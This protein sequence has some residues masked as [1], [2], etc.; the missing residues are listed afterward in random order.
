MSAP[1]PP[2]G[3]YPDGSTPNVVR[4]FDG[5]R[6][7]EHVT[8]VAPAAAPAVGYAAPPGGYASPAGGYGSPVGGYAS[9]PGGYVPGSFATAA[10][11]PTA[12]STDLGPGNGL[13]WV[14]PVGRS[15]QSIVAG[16]V[17]LFALF[18]WFMGMAGT[19][20]VAFGAVVGLLSVALGILAI[21]RASTGGHGRGRAWFAVVAGALCLVMT[22]VVAAGA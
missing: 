22:V 14:L 21:R 12:P 8:P 4:W 18:A 15:W 10:Y 20:G 5:S 17:G 6:W 2:A 19:A 3:W 11:G 7:T 1:L 9:P 13:H 16:Y